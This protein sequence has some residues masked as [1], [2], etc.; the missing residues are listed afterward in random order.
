MTRFAAR[1]SPLI[2]SDIE[3]AEFDDWPD[4]PKGELSVQALS[5]KDGFE[6]IL[7]AADG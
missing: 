5:Q 4:W 2:A 3:S 1:P 7:L 6:I